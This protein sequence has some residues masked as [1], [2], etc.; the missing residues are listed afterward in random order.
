MYGVG[1]ALQL[2]TPIAF[3]PRSTT[4]EWFTRA[5]GTRSWWSLARTTTRRSSTTR[6]SRAGGATAPG[7]PQGTW[8]HGGLPAGRAAVA[9]RA[10]GR[11]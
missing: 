8:W 1:D 5:P 9:G 10:S 7:A 4:S 3:E 11:K 6:S 2:S